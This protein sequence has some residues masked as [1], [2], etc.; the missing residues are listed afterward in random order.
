MRTHIGEKPYKC[1][2]CDKAFSDNISLTK[3]IRIHADNR[4]NHCDKVFLQKS[5]LKAHV[6][7]HK[8]FLVDESAAIFASKISEGPIYDCCCCHR[9]HYRFSVVEMKAGNYKTNK[10]I[11]CI[12]ESTSDI[13]IHG[14]PWVCNTCHK[15]LKT[16]KVPAQSWANGLKLDVIPPDLAD[17]RPLELRLIS[18]RI[19]FMKLVGLAS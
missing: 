13:G 11:K 12:L 2:V 16:G 3:H 9:L 5:K 4:C 8:E 19:P 6:K 15:I 7:T 10:D 18:Q 1:S 17:L 14:K